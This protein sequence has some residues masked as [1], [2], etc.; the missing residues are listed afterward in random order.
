MQQTSHFQIIAAWIDSCTT[1]MQ[2]NACIDFIQNRLKTDEK[3]IDDLAAYW[4]KR[5][6][7]RSWTSA[8]AA[9]S[10]DWTRLSEEQSAKGDLERFPVC[11]EYHEPQPT[12][13]C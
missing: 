5:N 13:Q 6:N 4:N 3:T 9:L 1:E 7:H 8:K 10:S 2:M 12:D 11:D